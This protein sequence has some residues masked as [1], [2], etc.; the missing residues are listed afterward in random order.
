MRHQYEIL[1]SLFGRRSFCGKPVVEREMLA[2]FS[3]CFHRSP[4]WPCLFKKKK[5]TLGDEGLKGRWIYQITWPL[6][7]LRNWEER[8][9]LPPPLRI[10][11]VICAPPFPPFPNP[12]YPAP[13]PLPFQKPTGTAQATQCFY[14]CCLWKIFGFIQIDYPRSALDPKDMPIVPKNILR[15]V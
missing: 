2:V 12:L 11:C 9:L 15:R 10:V 1:R 7:E 14:K 8:E 4:I 5:R 13:R 3:G 6:P